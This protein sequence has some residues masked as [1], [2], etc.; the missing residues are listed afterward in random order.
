MKI[1]YVVHQFFPNHITG[2]ERL[3]LN[4]AKQIQRMGHEV[5]VLTY[6]PSENEIEGFEQLDNIIMKKEYQFDRAND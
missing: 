5:T 6:E 2:T 3:T 1:L 4:I